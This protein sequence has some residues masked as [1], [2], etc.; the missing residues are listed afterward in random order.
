MKPLVLAGPTAL[1]DALIHW[2]DQRDRHHA[3]LTP[4]DTSGRQWRSILRQARAEIVIDLASHARDQAYAG[5]RY[6]RLLDACEQAD[7]PYFLVSDAR[8]LSPAEKP[9]REEQPL[10]PLD[11][12]GRALAWR[13]QQLRG[14]PLRSLVLRSGILFDAR[15]DG[16]L[17]HLVQALRRADELKLSTTRQCPP[18][19]VADLARVIS[20]LLDQLSCGANCWETYHY[21]AS[22]AT[23]CYEFTEMVL[24]N[25]SQYWNIGPV[26]LRE[27]REHPVAVPQLACHHIRD[28]FGIKQLP[29]RSF[30]NPSLKQL[31]TGEQS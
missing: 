9:L 25:A 18:T 12:Q 6:R 29:W 10:Q 24:A 1:R 31:H 17:G 16:R 15:P 27:L 23:S 28:H 2:F 14:R 3:A 19:H 26:D 30:L 21:T 20:A 13:E 8:V 4:E 5:E 11:D 22:G 7:I